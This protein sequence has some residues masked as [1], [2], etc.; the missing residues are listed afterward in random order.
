MVAL[1]FWRDPFLLLFVVGHAKRTTKPE[2][3]VT[4]LGTDKAD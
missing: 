1:H 4:K 3:N 2:G